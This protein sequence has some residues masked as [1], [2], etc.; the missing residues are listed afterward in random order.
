MQPRAA[1]S[2]VPTQNQFWREGVAAGLHKTG[3]L[4]LI[5][6]ASRR[7]ELRSSGVRFAKAS[8][9]KCVILC[10]HR[11][12]SGGAPL[13]SAQDPAV[14]ESQMRYLR[15]HYHLVSLDLLAEELQDVKARK[16]QQSVAITFD[17]GYRDIFRYAFP[18]LQR[19]KIPA[20]VYLTA[21]AI[22]RN[23]L[24]W[25][26]RVFVS[27][28]LAPGE[29]LDVLLARPIRFFLPTPVARLQA[30]EQIISYLRTLPDEERRHFCS[31][32]ERQIPV[33]PEQSADRMLTWEQARIMQAEG[34]VFGSHTL[35]HPAISR[36]TQAALDRELRES[37]SK[38]EERLGV[39]VNHF[40]YPFGKPGDYSNTTETVKRCGYRTAA[41]T[42][43]GINMPGVN[44]YELRR[45][46]IGEE[47]NL[48][49][50]GMKLTQLFLSSDTGDNVFQAGQSKK[51]EPALSPAV[52]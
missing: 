21:D 8:S 7:Y 13:Y 20:T 35:A 52:R 11:I 42:N 41:T 34:V 17:D 43:W 37:K 22:E 4:R 44:P 16:A 6:S 5:Q 30:A 27:L 49:V 31:E 15:E 2:L 28:S 50:F 48:A 51:V 29:K 47:R 14:F 45:V 19:Y 24:A 32:L 33:P 10:Y 3:L 9:T 12:G 26:D 39:T 46:S 38:V 23:E 25:Y 36:L 40:A 18:V 1:D